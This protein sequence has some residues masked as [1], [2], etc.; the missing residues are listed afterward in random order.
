MRIAVEAHPS[1]RV[2]RVELTGDRLSVWVRARAVQGQANSAI[3][4]AIARALNLRRR[5]VRLIGG[6]T[7]RHKLVEVDVE[8]LRDVQDRLARD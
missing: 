8:S 2:E 6:A 7:S 5:D 1:A 4:A 3:E